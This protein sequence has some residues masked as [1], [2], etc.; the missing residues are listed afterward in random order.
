MDG[1]A[2]RFFI[3]SARSQMAC[4]GKE[5]PKMIYGYSDVDGAPF[6]Q[7]PDVELFGTMTQAYC[8]SLAAA[9]YY[10]EGVRLRVPL[11]YDYPGFHG[12]KVTLTYAD[13]IKHLKDFVGDFNR[14]PCGAVISMR[15]FFDHLKKEVFSQK[16]DKNTLTPH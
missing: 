5:A 9:I 15:M 13:L 1:R 10:R 12:D 14:L 7:M 3:S 6:E 11:D 16:K 4:A 2:F 8:K